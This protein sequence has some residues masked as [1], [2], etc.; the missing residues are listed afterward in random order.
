ME[1]TP[2][3]PPDKAAMLKNLQDLEAGI[4]HAESAVEPTPKDHPDKAATLNN[5]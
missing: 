1:A 5:L 3:N 2:E 4:V